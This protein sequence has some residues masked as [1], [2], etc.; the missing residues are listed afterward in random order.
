MR[1]PIRLPITLSQTGRFALLVEPF[2]GQG[3]ACGWL[4][5]C[6]EGA[7]PKFSGPDANEHGLIH[8]IYNAEERRLGPAG[9]PKGTAR[10][11][12]LEVAGVEAVA[13]LPAAIR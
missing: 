1:C 4:S 11:E 10:L 7:T 2:I 3:A 13:A 8:G 5:I 6:V 9:N 12:D